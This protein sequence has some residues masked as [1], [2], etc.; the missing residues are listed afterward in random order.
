MIL[1]LVRM[2]FNTDSNLHAEKAML[3]HVAAWGGPI[4][5][6]TL[7]VRKGFHMK[8]HLKQ[9]REKSDAPGAPGNKKR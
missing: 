2:Y 9:A 3:L 1:Q 7:T 4:K 5:H 6:H 8:T